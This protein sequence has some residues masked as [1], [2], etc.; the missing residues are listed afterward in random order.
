MAPGQMASEHSL[1]EDQEK[2]SIP[3]DARRT[4]D[5]FEMGPSLAGSMV[6]ASFRHPQAM[7]PGSPLRHR[8]LD[9][10]MAK[11]VVSRVP[12]TGAGVSLRFLLQVLLIAFDS[13]PCVGWCGC[14]CDSEP[15]ADDVSGH[16]ERGGVLAEDE[17]GVGGE[18]DAVELERECVGVFVGG[19]FVLFECGDDELVD[20][21]GEAALKRGE[22]FFDRS[23]RAPIS[24]TA[25]AK[26]SRRE[27]FAVR[28]GGRTRRRSRGAGRVPAGR[29][30][31]V[32]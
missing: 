3:S 20:Q 22:L 21:C 25:P 6:N 7:A 2:F 31:P 8:S 23:G 26:N 11:L 16:V 17:V 1:W 30:V 5:A 32:R 27:T 15:S 24:R 13:V 28:D 9:V 19:E 12:D 18:D 29:R 14:R 4:R 10:V